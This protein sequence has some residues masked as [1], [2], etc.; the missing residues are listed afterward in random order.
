LGGSDTLMG[1]G[2]ADTMRGGA[3]D[4]FYYVENSGDVVTENADQGIDHVYST[5]S[6]TLAANVETLVLQAGAGAIDGSGNALDNSIYGNESDNEIR[7]YDGEDL[8]KGG[9]GAD[10]LLGGKD[11]DELHGEA[12][13]DVLGGGAGD[14]QMYGGTDNDTY[15][16]NSAGDVVVEYANQGIDTVNSGADSYTLTANVENLN[17]SSGLNGTGNGLVNVITGNLV[18]N[19]I[20]GRG[21][22]D[23]MEG[24][25]GNDT[26]I[27]D[28]AGDVVIESSDQGN[29]TVLASVS[30]ALGGGVSVETLATTSDTGTAAINLTGNGI[31]NAIRGNDGNNILNGGFGSDGLNG[32]EGIDTASYESNI[33]RVVVTLGQNGA[34]GLGYEFGPGPTGGETLLSVD[35]LVNIENVRGS[36]F[37]DTLVGN[38]LDNVLD[39]RSGA[40][41]MSGGVGGDTY[42]VDNAGDT[43]AENGGQGTDAV[44]SSVTYRLTA[45]AE[46]ENLRTTN[47]AGVGAITL[48][49]NEFDNTI[50]GNNGANT[51]AGSAADDGGAYD[52]LDVLT[53]HGGADTFTW[54]STGET[55]V[56][57]GEADVV[58]DFVRLQGDLLSFNLID[59][60]VTN[61]AAVN[62]AFTFVGVVNV[63]AGASF[64]APGQIG[65][66]SNS[67]DTFILLN[68]DADGFQEATIRLEGVHTVDAGWFV[69]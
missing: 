22:A 32:R 48:I 44:L 24:R 10:E 6:H 11:N 40:D 36:N 33:G 58:T 4:D 16:V 21:G 65:F 17:L 2:G 38:E 14:D 57:G 31:N 34:P 68:T 54:S 27:V 8:L 41:T 51:L 18:D 26:Y 12:G 62:D 60:N 61:G 37:N 28:N 43:I 45:G 64:T 52:G 25:Q 9:G 55:G 39:G 7:G 66:F 23:T 56:A 13:D 42:M 35:T 19:V 15:S 49:G 30:Y 53:G 63:A 20:D 47:D 59:A 3:G 50:D 46:V 1:G 29:D 67:T 5:I 69:L